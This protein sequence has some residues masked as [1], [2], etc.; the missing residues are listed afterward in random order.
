MQ[1]RSESRYEP[2]TFG[3]CIVPADP[4]SEWLERR[5][6]D[7]ERDNPPVRCV[8][9]PR[10]TAG[11]GNGRGVVGAQGAARLTTV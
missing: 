7:R 11:S 8:V 9:R 3:T 5:E 6:A 10:A 4:Y 1:N 2:E